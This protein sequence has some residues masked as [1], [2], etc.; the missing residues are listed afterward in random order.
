MNHGT[1]QQMDCGVPREER[2][3]GLRIFEE[4][5]TKNFPNWMKD[6][7]I[8]IQEAQQTPE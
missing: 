8:N 7:I 6:M 5:R 3:K 4:I 1:E 2:R